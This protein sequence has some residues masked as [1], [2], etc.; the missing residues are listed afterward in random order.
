VAAGCL[1]STRATSVLG[2]VPTP[3][4]EGPVTGGSGTPLLR[5][6]SVDLRALGY[7]QHEYLVAGAASALTAAGPLSSDGRWTAVP[8]T[9]APY[10]TR[11]VVYRPTEPEHFNGTVLVEWLNVSTFVDSAG[12]WVT[13]HTE[14]IR[15]GYAFV[16]A[17]AQQIG[18]EGGTSVL[19][20]PF[21]GSGPTSGSPPIRT[22]R[23]CTSSCVTT[24]RSC[25]SRYRRARCSAGV[26]DPAGRSPAPVGSRP[27][28]SRWRGAVGPR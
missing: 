26:R 8:T 9:T 11:I 27:S 21:L 22:R 13:G 7:E 23:T 25:G 28:G 2:Q 14:L 3:T 10:R 24:T 19:G 20:L 18:V 17:S 4:V 15:E 6:T 16:G 5:T 12:E 1:L